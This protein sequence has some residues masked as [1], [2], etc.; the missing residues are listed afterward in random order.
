MYVNFVN[1]A[2]VLVLCVEFNGEIE[3]F[4]VKLFW[5]GIDSELGFVCVLKFSCEIV[6]FDL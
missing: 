6:Q 5:I 3:V 2:S 4:F 1:F